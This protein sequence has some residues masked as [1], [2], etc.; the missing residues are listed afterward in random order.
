MFSRLTFNSL[1]L[2]LARIGTQVGLALFT[3]ILARQFGSSTFGEY[4]FIASVIVVGNALTTFGTDMMLIRDIAAT[5]ELSGLFPALVIQILLSI[6]F[7]A[8]TIVASSHLPNLNPEAV[9]ALRIY[10]FSLIPLAFFTVFTTI[11]RGKQRMV[12][13]ASLNL[14]LTILQLAAIFWLRLQVGGIINLV[15]LLLLVQVIGT[16]LAGILCH[17][18][19]QYSSQSWTNITRQLGDLIRICAPIALLGIL[20]ILYQRLSLII[21]LSLGGPSPTGY[22]SAAARVVEAAKIGHVA[23]FT[24][25]YPLM[26]QVNASGK[27]NWIGTFRLPVLVLLGGAIITSNILS[28]LAKPFIFILFGSGYISSISPLQVLAWM[29]IPYTI[30]SFLSLAFLA[31]GDTT[32][33]MIA[34]ISGIISLTILTIWWEP[35]MNLRGAAWAAL[36]A[37]ILQSIILFTRYIQQYRNALKESLAGVQT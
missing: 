16:L 33:I 9:I 4:T 22:Y 27:S 25:L 6:I 1:W 2:L 26:A 36:S 20:G 34:L 11:L 21:I 28:L 8:G 10:C 15:I 13:Y 3:I 30:N 18:Q 32:I 14:A 7:I 35:L 24:A 12:S 23:V 17:F 5:D 19:I 31:E 29:L 37:E